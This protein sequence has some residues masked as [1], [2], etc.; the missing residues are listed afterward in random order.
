MMIMRLIT[1]SFLV[2]ISQAAMAQVAGQVTAVQSPSWLERGEQVI[3][4]KPGLKIEQGDV[5]R[6]GSNGKL[7]LNM[8]DDSD[9]KLGNDSKINIDIVE[10][11]SEKNDNVFGMAL[12]VLKGVFR[13][14]T[15]ALGQDKKRDIAVSFGTVT[16]GIRGTDI[17]GRVNQEKDLVCLL[18]GSIDVSHP[19]SDTVYLDEALQYYDAPKGEA[20]SIKGKVDSEKVKQ[21]A[22][23]TDFDSENGVMYEGGEWSV[24][25]MSLQNRDY[26]EVFAQQLNTQ[27]YPAEIQRVDLAQG[28]FHRVV[29]GHFVTKDSAQTAQQDLSQLAGVENAWV[30][31]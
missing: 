15:S 1:A 21:W 14:T 2:F 19:Q 23:L 10:N 9:I 29:L 16:A 28:I 31:P 26:A 8:N 4:L 12:N 7:L 20:G 24:V 22:Q 13:F 25:L 30:R 27:G 18:E 6:T 5:I 11:A 17:W 3:A